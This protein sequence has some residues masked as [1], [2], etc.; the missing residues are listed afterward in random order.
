M[1]YDAI[2]KLGRGREIKKLMGNRHL[3]SAYRISD[4]TWHCEHKDKYIFFKT[5]GFT[6]YMGKGESEYEAAGSMLPL[7]TILSEQVSI[8]DILLALNWTSNV[9]QT[10]DRN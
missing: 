8:M 5:Q 10:W 7:G 9:D 3:D 6:L 1:Y 4:S 2:I